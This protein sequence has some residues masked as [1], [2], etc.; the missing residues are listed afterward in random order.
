MD[1]IPSDNPTVADIRHY[2]IIENGWADI[3]VADLLEAHADAVREDG[4]TS[5]TYAQWEQW[6]QEEPEGN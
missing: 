6:A 3:E 2:L 4:T 1:V 5:A